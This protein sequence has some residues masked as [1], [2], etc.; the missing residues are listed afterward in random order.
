MARAPKPAADRRQ[1]D[2]FGDQPLYPVRSPLPADGLGL[3]NRLARAIS[4]ALRECDLDR[5]AVAAG[6]ARYLGRDTFSKH[7]LDAYSAES[8][9]QHRVPAEVYV[10]L[11]HV[12]GA[13]WLL[14]ELAKP[15]GCVVLEG[16]EA[17]L[18]E[19]GRIEVLQRQLDQ[20]K[21]A[22]QIPARAADRRRRP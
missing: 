12:T 7:M 2:L 10:A 11:A 16:E 15:L 8:R 6:I 5:E 18:A 4:R 17:H 1:A 22:L 3:G 14:D 19:L 9:E 21:A 20:R 13:S